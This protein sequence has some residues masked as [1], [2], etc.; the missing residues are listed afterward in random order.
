MTIT[1]KELGKLVKK[2][3]A[4]KSKQIGKRYT[5]AMLAKDIGKSQSYI[6][7]I[8]SGRTYPT[9]VV[10]NAIA[11]ACNV[12]L[13]FFEGS[14][15]TVA[16]LIK[17][18]RDEHKMSIEEFAEMCKLDPSLIKELENNPDYFKEKS[19]EETFNILEKLSK[20]LHVDVEA[21]LLETGFLGSQ[22]EPLPRS[23]FFR[24][25]HILIPYL[26]FFK[27]PKTQNVIELIDDTVYIS[28][29]ELIQFGDDKFDEVNYFYFRVKDDSMINAR[30]AEGDLILA[31]KQNKFDNGDIVVVLIDENINTLRRFYKRNDI[32]I[33]QPENPKYQ[34]LMLTKNDL[35]NK[36]AVIIGRAMKLTIHF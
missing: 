34:P 2:A 18:Y 26:R 20:G 25:E 7:D 13:S 31:R 28:S 6:G 21:V 30:I 24:L 33:L 11:E 9:F 1:K 8:E 5:Q 12:P 29:L 35:E 3:R 15:I 14:T 22:P 17:K 10:L 19:F 27:D 4:I 16:K 36:K 32:I 23:E